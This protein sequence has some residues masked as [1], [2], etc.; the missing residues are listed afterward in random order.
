MTQPAPITLSELLDA[1]P[2]GASTGDAQRIRE[3]YDFVT[4]AHGQRR[5]QSQE[6]YVEHDLA[7]ANIAAEL[8]MDVTTVK[9]AL[10]HDSLLPHTGKEV[11]DLRDRFNPEVA[12]LVASLDKLTPYT[13]KHDASRDDKTLEA[14][15]RAILT[16]IEGDIRVVLVHLADRLQDLRMAGSLPDETRK[17]LAT[18]ARDINAPL[19]NRLGIWQLKWELEDLA[20]R[21]LDRDQYNWIARQISERRA[22]RDRRIKEAADILRSRLSEEGIVAEIT[23]RPK[24][25]YSI[26]RKIRD[27][28]LTFDRI[29]DIR[30]L[31]VIVADDD[32]S[33][34]YQV[35]GVVHNLWKPIPHEFDDYVARAKPNGYQS[36]H[37][38]VTDSRGRTLEVQIRT[39]AMHEEAEKGIAAHWAYKEGSRQKGAVNEQVNL[40]RQ[41][42]GGV[43]ESGG[44]AIEDADIGQELLGERVFVF[45]PRGDVIDLPAGSTPIDFAYA[46]HTQVGHRCR[47]A[48]VN[49]KMV[50]LDYRLTS[51]EQVEI[52][53]A[54][55]GGP[56]RDWMNE[57]LGYAGS[58]R[59]RSKV[60]SWFR[61][62]ERES[63]IAQGREIV[64]R[65]LKRLGVSDVYTIQDIAQALK[66]T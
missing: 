32:P 49:G 31:R 27:K 43:R 26:H 40:L 13:E 61:Q 55:K 33:T 29:Y 50:S 21:Y 2:E 58:A 5:R 42:L 17:L 20:F 60:R 19:A 6:L 39:R 56:S 1:L 57:A 37:T 12:D 54:K 52:V 16:I 30:A 41:L 36:L 62:Q 9:A 46:I 66:F 23:G 7:V 28:G 59:T 8:G 45:T 65:E 24:H 3:A 64:L 63:N 44:T 11:V 4:E 48:R 25:I 10:L 35:L 34:C 14:I 15:R 18:E 22:E 51:G 53:T 47:G 38:A